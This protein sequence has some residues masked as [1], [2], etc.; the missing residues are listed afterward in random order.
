[1]HSSHRLA[2]IA[3]LPLA[4]LPT[5]AAAEGASF[6]ASVGTPGIGI[7]LSTPLSPTFS[8]RFGLNA[9]NY[10]DRVSQSG[11]D[12]Q[13]DLKLRS[14]LILLDWY[15]A[16]S[17]FRV[18]GGLVFNENYLD[19]RGVARDGSFSIGGVSYPAAQVGE[20]SGEVRF[21]SLA[22]YVGFGYSKGFGRDG[23][24][25][26]TFDAG[27]IVQGKP[28]VSLT[29][30]GPAADDPAFQQSLAQEERDLEDDLDSFR[31][32]PVLSLGV[33]YGF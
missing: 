5:A 17:G 6:N 15:P 25:G 30:R 10:D 24:W 12:Y 4:F 28:E 8:A 18:S 19:A 21:R 33:R 29:A 27:V 1:M 7:A 31:Y 2:A 32:F 13:A 22:P 14:G 3:W 16:G 23:R 11:I 20:L 9:F 26:V